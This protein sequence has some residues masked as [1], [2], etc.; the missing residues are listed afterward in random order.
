MRGASD[1]ARVG[2]IILLFIAINERHAGSKVAPWSFGDY[3]RAGC[4]L[5]GGEPLREIYGDATRID[6]RLEKHIARLIT[7]QN[8]LVA[9]AS[10]A[11]CAI[12]LHTSRH[13]NVMRYDA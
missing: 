12:R 9:R 4:A 5:R 3:Y 2:N 1:S 8:Y 11:N 13:Y 6:T 7:K 10:G